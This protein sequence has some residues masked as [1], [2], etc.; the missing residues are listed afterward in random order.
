[1][2]KFDPI[3]YAK[4]VA[5]HLDSVFAA[6]G[7]RI[8]GLDD[9]ITALETRE[10]KSLADSFK[11]TWLPGKY[12]RGDLIQHRGSMWLAVEDGD[13]KPGE[14]SCWRLLVQ[15]GKDGKAA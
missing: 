11:G 3:R 9:R 1:M 15:R 10:V 7:G 4:G 5:D 12:E 2:S 8:R 13:G 6:F 14:S